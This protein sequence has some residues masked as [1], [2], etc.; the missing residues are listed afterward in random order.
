[1]LAADLRVMSGS[2]SGDVISLQRKKFLIGREQDCHLRPN[3]EMVSRHH[4][5]F[6]IDD[7]SVRLRDLGSTNGTLVNGN[8]IRSEVLLE[9]GDRIVIGNLDF[10]I[11]IS[12]KQ[13]PAEDSVAGNSTEVL[14]VQETQ[15]TEPI[16]A[17]PLQPVTQQIPSMP[18]G[19]DT[20]VLPL[21]GMMPPGQPYPQMMPQMGFPGVPG[22]NA[23]M[24]SGY[25][26]MFPGMMY[27]PFGTGMPGMPGMQMAMPEAAA[28]A[29]PA[30]VGKPQLEVSLPDP[31]ETGAVD[32]S[33][34]T[35]GSSGAN[36]SDTTKPTGAANDIIRQY[37]GRRPPGA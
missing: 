4:C 11:E 13:R 27:P 10:V 17:V 32:V 35:K 36:K 22:F 21:Q 5:A 23:G 25:G 24:M 14:S 29:D 18:S 1:M 8:R 28:G 16:P 12:G 34:E 31:S 19:T 2:H 7:F 20:V 3:S 15:A 33:T 30:P 9:D 26:Q 6:S 37:M